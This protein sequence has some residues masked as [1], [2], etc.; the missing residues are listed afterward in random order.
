MGWATNIFQKTHLVTLDDYR[1]LC[2]G[3]GML[4][5]RP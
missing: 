2:L 1:D 4:Y 5:L 3:Q